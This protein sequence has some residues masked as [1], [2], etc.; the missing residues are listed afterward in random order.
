MK[1]ILYLLRAKGHGRAIAAIAPFLVAVIG[2]QYPPPLLDL[3]INGDTHVF[4]YNMCV[5]LLISYFVIFVMALGELYYSRKE[6][7][8]NTNANNGVRFLVLALLILICFIPIIIFY[9]RHNSFIASFNESLA[10]RYFYVN[11]MVN[12]EINPHLWLPQGFLTTSI[13]KLVFFIQSLVISPWTQLNLSLESFGYLTF[14]AQG[15]IAAL[16]LF[17][18]MRDNKLE[19]I[20]KT[21]VVL[22]LFIPIYGITTSIY[23]SYYTQPDYLALDIVLSAGFLYYFFL[24]SMRSDQEISLKMVGVIAFLSGVSVSN[25]ISLIFLAA[26]LVV[27]L[28]VRFIKQP[29]YLL[30]ISLISIPAFVLGM[31]LPWLIS[32]SPNYGIWNINE[33]LNLWLGFVQNAPQEGSFIESLKNNL[34]TYPQYIRFLIVYVLFWIFFLIYRLQRYK[35]RSQQFLI[36]TGLLFL[37]VL[38]FFIM[39]KVRSAGTTMFE[40]FTMLIS[41]TMM[42]IGFVKTE[43]G[44]LSRVKLGFIVTCFVIMVSFIMKGYPNPNYQDRGF[45]DTSLVLE[46]HDFA[47]SYKR[48]VIVIIPDNSF[49]FGSIEELFL[50]GFSDFPTW[51]ITTGKILMDEYAPNLSYRSDYIEQ[52]PEMPYPTGVVIMWFDKIDSSLEKST[53]LREAYPELQKVLS[54]IGTECHQ[55]F[56]E[57]GRKVNICAVPLSKLDEHM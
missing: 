51:N 33:Y 27:L 50:K 54:T 6:K 45:Q 3:F 18:V 9:A 17:F 8:S 34:G 15:L 11:R 57:K 53:D 35:F 56:F 37:A 26:A 19:K 24:F 49:C 40:T 55:W 46:I 14:V 22:C 41:F 28:G 1:S 43:E 7:S 47:L 44:W 31:L 39:L 38:Q 29:L 4:L 2:I 12:G 32:Q 13:Q 21:L 23:L 30:Y 36:S 5:L 48:P 25:K 10:Y 52:K 42:I 16:L 20:Q